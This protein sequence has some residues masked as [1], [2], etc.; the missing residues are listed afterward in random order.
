MRR[1]N[2]QNGLEQ[3]Q[4]PNDLQ[5]RNKVKTVHLYRHIGP[6]LFYQTYEST[7][8][9]LAPLLQIPTLPLLQ[10]LYYYLSKFLVLPIDMTNS[11]KHGRKNRS[12]YFMNI[13]VTFLQS[14]KYPI[15]LLLL[16]TIVKFVIH[17][18][19]SQKTVQ[20]F[21]HLLLPNHPLFQ[22]Y[23]MQEVYSL[24]QRV[25]TRWSRTRVLE[26]KEQV[27]DGPG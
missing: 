6:H 18:D 25:I 22:T 3:H 7:V 21:R 14:S 24:D 5:N 11:L 23:T 27:R 26:Q 10:L 19:I 8:Y 17:K 9:L 12:I 15:Q 20:G 13:R 2:K 16:Q 1:V 4:L